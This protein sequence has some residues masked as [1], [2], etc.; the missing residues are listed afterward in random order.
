MGSNDT[1]QRDLEC[2]RS[3]HRVPGAKIEGMEAQLVYSLGLLMKGKGQV[4]ADAPCMSPWWCVAEVASRVWTFMTTRTYL[5]NKDC[6][7]ETGSI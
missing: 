3:D 7:G 4:E 6:W 5:R 1:V 2:A